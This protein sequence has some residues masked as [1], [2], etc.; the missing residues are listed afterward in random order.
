M[1][2]GSSPWW[3]PSPRR[4]LGISAEISNGQRQTRRNITL[5]SQYVTVY[6]DKR[7]VFTFRDGRQVEVTAELWKA[8]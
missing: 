2:S 8:A 7:L 5:T 3:I 4:W 6:E 1:K